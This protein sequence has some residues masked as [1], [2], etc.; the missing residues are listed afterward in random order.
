MLN[1]FDSGDADISYFYTSRLSGEP[2]SGIA[3]VH[4]HPLEPRNVRLSIQ[5]RLWTLCCAAIAFLSIEL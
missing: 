3:D 1:V 4:Y 5:Y 2:A